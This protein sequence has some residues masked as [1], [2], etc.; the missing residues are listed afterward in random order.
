MKVFLT[1]HSKGQETDYIWQSPG[2]CREAASRYRDLRR[3]RRRQAGCRQAAS[4]V[5]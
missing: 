3:R 2:I 1:S 4:A 5:G